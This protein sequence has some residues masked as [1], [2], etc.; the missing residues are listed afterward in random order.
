LYQE[1]LLG[2]ALPVSEAILWS[3]SPER[4][5]VL[6]VVTLLEYS[7]FSFCK[8]YNSRVE[9]LTR[10]S[11]LLV[12]ATEEYM[13]SKLFSYQKLLKNPAMAS[14]FFATNRLLDINL[15]TRYGPRFEDYGNIWEIREN[16]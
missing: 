4:G 9:P 11:G 10:I 5:N 15:L 8:I 12:L 1:L 6:K 14:V 3:F 13:H 7:E 16:V 2:S